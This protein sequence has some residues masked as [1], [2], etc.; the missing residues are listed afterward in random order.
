MHRITNAKLI[1]KE[2]GLTLKHDKLRK[3]TSNFH[4]VF[5]D[6]HKKIM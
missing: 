1:L 2:N 5:W 3:K 4:L 6:D